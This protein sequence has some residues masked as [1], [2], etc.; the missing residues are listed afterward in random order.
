M[1][2]AYH[3]TPAGQSIQIRMSQELLKEIDD[4][5]VSEKMAS[6]SEAMRVLMKRG[7]ERMEAETNVQHHNG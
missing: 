4:W 3:S 5:G 7:L 6:R 1:A 2:S